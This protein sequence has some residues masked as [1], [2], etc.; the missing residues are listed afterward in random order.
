M[1]RIIGE[2]TYLKE[3]ILDHSAN[4]LFLIYIFFILDITLL[5]FLSTFPGL[6]LLKNVLA[7]ALLGVYIAFNKPINREIRLKW[8][9]KDG[10]DGELSV[11]HLLTT[12]PDS[13]CIF[14]NVVLPGKKSNIDFVVIGPSGVFSIEVKSHKGRIS[15]DGIQLLRNGWEFEHNFLWQAKGE[16]RD[17][18]TYLSNSG[19]EIPFVNPVL[20]FSSNFVSIHF[21]KKLT[22]GVMVLGSKWLLEGIQND[23]KN[24][25]LSGEQ[26]AKIQSVLEKIVSNTRI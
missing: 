5:I 6:D 26:V 20:V 15:F 3:Q 23:L 12:L 24:Q 8:N 19:V 25:S 2:D 13:Y 14:A 1:A 18:H 11:Q 21:G 16:A 10:L 9:Y 17:L 7:F 22:D 4:G